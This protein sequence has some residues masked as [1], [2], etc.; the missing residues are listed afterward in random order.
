MA[1]EYKLRITADAKQVGGELKALVQELNNP[2]FG[3]IGGLVQ[4]IQR[5]V[6][7]P[8]GFLT[9]ALA[10]V[11]LLVRSAV[12]EAAEVKRMSIRAGISVPEAEALS[13]GG[14]ATGAEPEELVARLNFLRRAQG[15]ALM[16][17]K[18]L[19]RSFQ[20]LGIELKDLQEKSHFELFREL[21]ERLKAGSLSAEQFAAASR[22][23]GRDW[24]NLQVA[25]QKGLAGKMAGFEGSLLAPSEGQR[26]AALAIGKQF[27]EGKTTIGSVISN[28]GYML[29]QGFRG[30]SALIGS[31]AVGP[32]SII[33]AVRAAQIDALTTR[34]LEKEGSGDEGIGRL[35][36]RLEQRQA[37]RDARKKFAEL[38]ALQRALEQQT[39]AAKGFAPIRQDPFAR[40]GLFLSHGTGELSFETLQLNRQSVAEL[41]AIKARIEELTATVNET[42]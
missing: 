32:L 15:N 6:V 8:I 14:R 13:F 26:E 22:L 36:L 34:Q 31:A 38:A 30:W 33:P 29:A 27:K 20:A 19:I 4:R 28:L 1:G 40:M 24:S 11:T 2:A 17:N 18:A 39:A 37:T 23:F 5:F 3:P 16:G 7:S 10:S 25:F 41:K 12:S 42:M 35:T 9:S 21:A